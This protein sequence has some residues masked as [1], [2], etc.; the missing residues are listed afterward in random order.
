[1]MQ[2]Y[3][4]LFLKIVVFALL[5]W[6]LKGFIMERTKRVKAS[7]QYLTL[8]EIKKLFDDIEDGCEGKHGILEKAMSK[9]IKHLKE[10]IEKDLDH[11]VKEF[12]AIRVQLGEQ[13]KTINDM[14]SILTS[15]AE[16]NGIDRTKK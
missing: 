5:I 4:D 14:S 16:K 10:L 13:C 7:E 2:P 15:W 8:E 9:D 6:A 1:M 11:G 12:E 3:A